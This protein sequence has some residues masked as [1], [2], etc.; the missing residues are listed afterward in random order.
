MEKN[1]K[2][3]MSSGEDIVLPREMAEA[4]LD[5]QIQQVKIMVNKQWT[6]RT[7]NK[8]HIVQTAPTN[9]A[10]S[11]VS[12]NPEN[13]LPKA[14]AELIQPFVNL[15]PA[16][17]KRRQAIFNKGRERLNRTLSEIN[18]EKVSVQ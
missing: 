14:P 17:K 2:F 9:D 1:I 18:G 12:D 11:Y 10:C 15:S 8:A 7:L 13:L 6:G 4:V 5:S 3:F 16:E